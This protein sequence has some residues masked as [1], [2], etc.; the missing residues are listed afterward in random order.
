M[1]IRALA[2]I[3]GTH[4]ARATT[5]KLEATPTPPPQSTKRT[6]AVSVSGAASCCL[7]AV[8]ML[9]PARFC[10]WKRYVAF[11]VE[12]KE[13]LPEIFIY[14]CQGLEIIAMHAG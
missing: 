8:S 7:C 6:K 12:A 4:A 2:T 11:T 13:L 10:I 1:V 5:A 3:Q 14:A 9:P